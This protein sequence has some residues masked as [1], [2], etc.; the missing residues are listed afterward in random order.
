MA[1]YGTGT[2]LPTAEFAFH[3]RYITQVGFG[4]GPSISAIQSGPNFY[5]TDTSNPVVHVR[6]NFHPSLWGSRSNALTLPYVLKDWW[7]IIDPSP[8]PLPLNFTMNFTYNLTP[9]HPT[10]LIYIP[11]WSNFYFYDIPPSPVGYWL[12]DL[13]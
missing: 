11:G 13:P 12:P 5:F 6:A 3:R 8:T 2:Y 9:L 4:F 7:L 1:I 10:L